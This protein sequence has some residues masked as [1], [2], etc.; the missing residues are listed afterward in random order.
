MDSDEI[1]FDRV[2]RMRESERTARNH[3]GEI[4]PIIIMHVDRLDPLDYTR[5]P[6]TLL[7]SISKF[8]KYNLDA[9]I[10]VSQAPG[11]ASFNTVERRLAPLSHDLS[12]L[13]LPPS[14]FGTHLNIIGLTIDAELERINA[15]RTGE[16]LADIWKM[17]MI[18]HHPVVVE[19]I[20]P[21]DSAHDIAI[22]I[23]TQF[24]LDCLIDQ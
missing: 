7:S 2:V 17:N 23:D 18:D 10:L 5:F 11:Q 19:Y 3:I 20:D 15:K 14:Y 1:D 16:L 4:K 13:V 9:F 8:K 21:P 6:K 22:G 24:T 12:G